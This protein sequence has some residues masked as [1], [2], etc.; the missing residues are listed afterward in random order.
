MS[1]R[2]EKCGGPGGK[3]IFLTKRDALDELQRLYPG[4][5]ARPGQGNVHRCTWGDHY[6]ITSH[7]K[8]SRSR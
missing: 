6:H 8:P 5:K 7:G 2:P 4:R 3:D 1:N